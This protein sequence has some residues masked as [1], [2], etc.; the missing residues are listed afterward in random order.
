MVAS[1]WLLAAS[2]C[3]LVA[4]TAESLGLGDD[5]NERRASAGGILDALTQ[6]LTH[7]LAGT[8]T[9]VQI[10]RSHTYAEESC[11]WCRY[12]QRCWLLAAIVVLLQRNEIQ[13]NGLVLGRLPEGEVRLECRLN[14]KCH[15]NSIICTRP[16]LLTRLPSG[17]SSWEVGGPTL[18]Q[19]S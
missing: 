18:S 11:P 3:L 17:S 14:F 15:F 8:H 16:S 6:I 9:Q 12:C 10:T 5:L 4:G 2:C 7:S 19:L 1:R 13:R